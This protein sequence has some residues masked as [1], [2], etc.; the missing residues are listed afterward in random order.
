MGLYDRDYYQD[1]HASPQRFSSGTRMMV[2]NLVILN[3]GIYLLEIFLTRQP[4]PTS[5]GYWLLD[6]L[7]VTP[8][9]LL[10]PWLWWKLLSY[11]FAHAPP[12]DIGHV[13]WNMFGLWVFGRDVESI[14][15]PKEFL[16]IYLTTIVLGGLVWCLRESLADTNSYLIGASGAVTAIILLFVLHFPKR[17]ILLMFVLPVPAWVVGL[18]I[19]GGNIM[20]LL[21][22]QNSDL[23]V[24][25]DVHLAGAVFAIAYFRFGWNLG[26]LLP[27][28]GG[29]RGGWPRFR[30]RP[31]LRVHDP[32]EGESSYHQE[33]A[34]ADRILDKVARDGMDSLSKKERR[35]LED[36]SRRMRQKH[37]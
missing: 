6:I 4:S 37:R 33:D 34:E 10:Q 14:Y 36:Y 12:P 26:R 22:A 13:F 31:Q 3:A 25:F 7:R 24:A 32:D 23:S 30:R 9:V 2:T 17:T 19:I 15:G 29:L 21:Q 8:E 20:M 1:D 18:L 11:G 28:F 16:R 27:D 35:I 5:S